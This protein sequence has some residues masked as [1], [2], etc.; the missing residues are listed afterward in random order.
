MTL[1]SSGQKFLKSVEYKFFSDYDQD[2]N[3]VKFHTP[4]EQRGLL[5]WNIA[6]GVIKY[7]KLLNKIN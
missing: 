2:Q 3:C 5:D 6:M 7:F 1:N 4:V